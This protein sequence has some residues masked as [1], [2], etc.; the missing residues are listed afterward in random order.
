MLMS[1]RN[2]PLL[3]GTKM[4][5]TKADCF[6]RVYS[7]DFDCTIIILGIVT[8]LL[9]YIDQYNFPNNFSYNAQCFLIMLV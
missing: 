6:I 8:V 9:E 1:L 3:A 5:V 2:V 7:F 4:F